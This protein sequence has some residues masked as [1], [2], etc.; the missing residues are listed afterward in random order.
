MLRSLV[1]ATILAAL[2]SSTPLLAQ[3]TIVVDAAQGAGFDFTDIPPAI[4]AARD[5]DTVVVRAGDY[6]PFI[7]DDKGIGVVAQTGVTIVAVVAAG[8]IIVDNLSAGKAASIR[9]FRAAGNYLTATYVVQS[10]AGR[11]LLEDLV[12]VNF[13]IVAAAQVQLHRCEWG[14]TLTGTDSSLAMNECV[15]RG[16]ERG[17]LNPSVGL[18]D[19]TA[20]CAACSFAAPIGVLTFPGGPGMQLDSA[21]VRL[22]GDASHAITAWQGTTSDPQSA[23]DGIGSIELD[24]DITLLPSLTAP[25]IGPGVTVHRRELPTLTAQAGAIGGPVAIDVAAGS[26]E[27][28]FL[29]WAPI[30]DVLPFPL[31]D[32]ELWLDPHAITLG[33]A[34]VLDA[35]G[36]TTFAFR[37]PRLPVLVGAPFAWQAVTGA[38]GT[39]VLSSPVGYAHL[40]EVGV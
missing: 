27:M 34:G 6:S 13:A 33:R 19:S 22:A 36:K 2:A 18:T 37:A 17:I 5:G 38:A 1:F 14:R 20:T 3:R 24:P 4:A 35:A 31:L 12:G 39:F 15:G 28:F 32:G 9:G 30:G 10:C 23:I 16:S 8:A 21:T 29:F 26:G 11:V 40:P 25:P 7:V